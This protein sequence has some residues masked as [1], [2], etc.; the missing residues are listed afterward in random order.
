MEEIAEQNNAQEST[1]E[2]TPAE[3]IEEAEQF[4]KDTFIDGGFNLTGKS[5]SYKNVDL[6][7]ANRIN[8]RMGEIY[9]QYNIKGLSSL[10]A[11]GKANKKVYARESDAPFFCSNYGN[12]GMNTTIMKS[13]KMLDA[14]RKDGN[15]A[16]N[17][18][19]ANMDSLTGAKLEL[20]KAYEIA[21]RSLVD[22]SLEGMVTHEIGHHISFMPE[23]NQSLADLRNSDWEDYAKHLS[24]YA[25]HSYGEYIAESWGAYYKGE[26]ELV[27]PELKEIFERLKK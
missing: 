15:D 10:E 16:F 7:V 19:M 27:Q 26:T 5:I 21:G 17:Y 24:G 25:N 20:A 14:Y 22:D 23:I 4:A 12:I 1:W 13:E 3:T 11:Y 18:V 2:F 8:N 6:D 9:S